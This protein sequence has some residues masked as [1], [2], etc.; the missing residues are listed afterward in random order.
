MFCMMIIFDE[1]YKMTMI[2]IYHNPRC[3]KSREAVQL[4]EAEE[5][6]FEIVDYLKQPP[7]VDELKD[8]I[9]MLDIAPIEL[10]RVK[11]TIW[12]EN[13]Q[14]KDLSSEEIIAALH[15]HPRLI[16]RPIV[17]RENQ[18]VIGRP[19]VLIKNIL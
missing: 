13:Y 3:S 9:K 6:A 1:N 10:V 14:G 7:T 17:V 5:L 8:L 18:A 15:A 4:L 12:K 19:P 16:E 2:K 11:E